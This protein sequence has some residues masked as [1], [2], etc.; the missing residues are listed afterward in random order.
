MGGYT[1]DHLRFL[2][3]TP[4]NSFWAPAN[5][6][7]LGSGPLQLV[8]ALTRPNNSRSVFALKFSVAAPMR[9]SSLSPR[10]CDGPSLTVIFKCVFPHIALANVLAETH[11]PKRQVT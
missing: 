1:L 9:C 11:K 6:H 8:L 10:V 5:C 2:S 3:T 7:S 4:D